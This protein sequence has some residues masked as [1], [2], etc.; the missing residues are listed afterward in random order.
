MGPYC[1][2]S[3][4]IRCQHLFCNIQK[5]KEWYGPLGNHNYV[6]S[7]YGNEQWYSVQLIYSNNSNKQP[8]GLSLLRWPISTSNIDKLEGNITKEYPWI[9]RR[10]CSLIE[11]TYF[12]EDWMPLLLF[13]YHE[14]LIIG[15]L[16]CP[17]NIRHSEVIFTFLR[18]S[19][20]SV[21]SQLNTIESTHSQNKLQA[22]WNL[23]FTETEWQLNGIKEFWY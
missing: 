9:G 22:T 7:R 12:T 6:S 20:T 21:N 23:I 8:E 17:C 3:D 4:W 14:K 19:C 13:R 15:C 10:C 11:C 1:V 2:Y 16:S 5:R 18:S